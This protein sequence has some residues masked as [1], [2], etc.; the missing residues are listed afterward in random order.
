MESTERESQRPCGRQK[1]DFRSSPRKVSSICGSSPVVGLNSYRSARKFDVSTLVMGLLIAVAMLPYL[2]VSALNPGHLRVAAPSRTCRRMVRE[3]VS[4][5]WG[6][7]GR[8]KARIAAV[9]GGRSRCSPVARHGRHHQCRHGPI[10]DH[11]R[12]TVGRVESRD[13]SPRACHVDRDTECRSRAS[14]CGARTRRCSGQRDI[15]QQQPQPDRRS[16]IADCV[17]GVRR[18]LV[19]GAAV[20]VVAD[21]HH[22][23]DGHLVARSR[24]SRSSKQACR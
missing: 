13:R 20:T 23:F 12:R 6:E 22:T 2:L 9:V 16:L 5:N 7:Y 19:D 8:R 21:R 14:S 24:H 1:S 18:R 4:D 17:H 10:S 11:A 15:Q 3:A